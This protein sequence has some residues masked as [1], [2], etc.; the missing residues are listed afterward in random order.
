MEGW[1]YRCIVMLTPEWPMIS[2]RDFTAIPFS[3]QR[4][5]KVCLRVWKVVS[6]TPAFLSSRLYCDRH[7]RG[8]SG[9]DLPL[10]R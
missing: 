7:V 9:A 8:Y 5:A 3:M 4:V 10:A 6:S 1:T 2:L